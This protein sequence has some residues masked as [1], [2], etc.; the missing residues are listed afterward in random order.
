VIETDVPHTRKAATDVTVLPIHVQDR[1]LHR[2]SFVEA[3]TTD[4]RGLTGLREKNFNF[5]TKF[6]LT[7][8]QN[9]IFRI[10]VAFFKINSS[11]VLILQGHKLQAIINCI[12]DCLI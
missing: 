9:D 7:F 5:Q 12:I 10:S 11:E 3:N 6:M 1:D 2:E 8:N 4:G